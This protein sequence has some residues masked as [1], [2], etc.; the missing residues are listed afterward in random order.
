MD[1]DDDDGSNNGSCVDD[2]FWSTPKGRLFRSLLNVDTDVDDEMDGVT[3]KASVTVVRPSS[4]IKTTIDTVVFIVIIIVVT[5]VYRRCRCDDALDR[6]T[7][8]CVIL[9]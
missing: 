8:V 2:F 3:T 7:V 1:T 9:M 4:I 5:I 6:S